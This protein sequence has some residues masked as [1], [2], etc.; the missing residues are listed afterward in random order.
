MCSPTKD[1]SCIHYPISIQRFVGGPNFQNRTRKKFWCQISTHILNIDFDSVQ[2]RETIFTLRWC[3]GGKLVHYTLWQWSRHMASDLQEYCW[4]VIDSNAYFWGICADKWSSQLPLQ[5]T[6]DILLWLL[7]YVEH[8]S[9]RLRNFTHGVTV[10]FGERRAREEMETLERKWRGVIATKPPGGSQCVKSKDLKCKFW[11][12]YSRDY[13]LCA[14]QC[15][16][17]LLMYRPTVRS[18]D[19]KRLPL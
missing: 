4:N 8:T 6:R 19:H 11:H 14:Y 3:F 2:L 13:K 16:G 9:W 5:P 7:Y 12:L 1:K 18:V 15:Y 10:K 17:P